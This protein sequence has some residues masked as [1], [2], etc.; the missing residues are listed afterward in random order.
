MGNTKTEA[1]NTDVGA[2]NSA[3]GSGTP[4][5]LH[6][7]LKSQVRDF[8]NENPCGAKFTSDVE[9]GSREFFDRV[10][11]HRYETEWHIRDVAQFDQWRGQDVLEIGCGLGTDAVQFARAG[12]HYT[13]VDLTPRAV[14]IVRGRF[15]LYGLEGTTRVADAENLPFEDATFDVVYSH[16]VLHHTPDTQRAFDEIYRVLRPGGRAMVMLYHRS[17]YN[18]HVNIMTLRRLGAQLLRFSR[19]P[20]VVSKITGEDPERLRYLRAKM[21]ADPKRFFSTEEFLNQNTDGAGN[22]LAKVY[23]RRQAEKMFWQFS[24]VRTEV[25]FLN[26]RWLPVPGFLL[27]RSVEGALARRF[28]WH[29]WIFATK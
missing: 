1:I 16:G 8:W 25:H 18:Y 22:P 28:G 20:E 29:L 4:P 5:A 6:S 14:E 17:S 10:E 12:A 19:G 13:G 7:A 27:P 21:L 24:Y 9:F 23:T 11:A 15:A 2:E 26:R 3:L